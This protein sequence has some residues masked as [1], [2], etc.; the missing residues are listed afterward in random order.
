MSAARPLHP[1]QRTN[2]EANLNVC[3][4]PALPFTPGY[5]LVGVV[6]KTGFGVPDQL[7]GQ[8]VADLCVVGGYT[9][10]C[11]P[12]RALCRAG[13]RCHRSRRGGCIPLAYLTAYQPTSHVLL[14]VS[15]LLSDTPE[16]ST[17]FPR[18]YSYCASD[19]TQASVSGWR[20]Q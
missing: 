14:A 20:F 11:D 18:D 3:I 19:R 15:R 7:T 17:Q 1:A 8:L 16:E 4:G 9:R 2:V 6:E 10:N 12:P 13:P 5:D